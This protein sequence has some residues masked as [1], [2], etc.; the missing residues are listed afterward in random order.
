MRNQ[1]FLAVF[2]TVLLLGSLSTANAGVVSWTVMQDASVSG[3]GPGP[4]DLIGTADDTITG[5]EE[6]QIRQIASELGL[7]H[8]EYIKARLAYTDKRSVFKNKG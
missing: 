2:L 5:D 8:R 3:M 4:D 6:E 7:S 1:V